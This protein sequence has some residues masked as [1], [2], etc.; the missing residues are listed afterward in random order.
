M[1]KSF[2]IL[3]AL[4]H[5]FHWQDENE[6]MQRKINILFSRIL[7]LVIVRCKIFFFSIILLLVANFNYRL[8]HSSK[9]VKI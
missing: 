3:E 8:F 9:E 6:N 4:Q 7:L 1:L 5:S 2:I